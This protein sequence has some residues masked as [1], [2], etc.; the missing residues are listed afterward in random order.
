MERPHICWTKTMIKG[1][2]ISLANH[3]DSTLASRQLIAS[4]NKTKSEID[5]KIL[6]ATTPETIGDDL[7]KITYIDASNLYYTYPQVGEKYDMRS[8]LRLRA[9]ETGNLQKRI[10]CMVSH[11]RV[12]Q[13]CIDQGQIIAVFEH[14][15]LFTR[16]LLKKDILGPDSKFKNGILGLNDPRGMTRKSQVF[17]ERAM[18][19]SGIQNVPQVDT[20]MEYP[21]GLAGNSAYLIM[22]EAARQL[23]N[24]TVEIGMWPNDALMCKQFF[25]WLQIVTP[26]YTTIQKG[27]TSTTTE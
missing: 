23:L 18:L 12:W 8:G 16:Q 5:V 19:H 10:A 3:H 17:H 13:E 7:K 2:I 4:I 25:P 22:P 24:K 14:D 9:Y 6:P 27:L 1:Y 20:T 15:A 11:M 21:Q 26:Y